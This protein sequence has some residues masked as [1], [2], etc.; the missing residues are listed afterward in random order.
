MQALE[1]IG[2]LEQDEE[3]GGRRVTQQGQRDL[4]RKFTRLPACCGLE[5]DL[6]QVS[7]RPSLRLRM[8]RMRRMTSKFVFLDTFGHF[9]RHRI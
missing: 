3:K 4:D 5:A 8:R 6:S 1:K 7:P 2:V 9:G